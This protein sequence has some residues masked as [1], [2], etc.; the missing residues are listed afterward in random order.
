MSPRRQ[1]P[2]KSR[3]FLSEEFCRALKRHGETNAA[4]AAKAGLNVGVL[5]HW[6]EGVNRA[7]REDPR[8]AKLAETINFPKDRIFENEFAHV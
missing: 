6:T 4:L 1:K 2:M 8:I 7:S 5:Y 3:A